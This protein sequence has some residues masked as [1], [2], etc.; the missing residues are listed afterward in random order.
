VKD[1][2]SMYDN[3]KMC[4][5]AEDYIESEVI[6]R[7]NYKEIHNL[8]RS[9]LDMCQDKMLKRILIGILIFVYDK[10]INCQKNINIEASND[11]IEN[12]SKNKFM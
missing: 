2:P 12:A 1:M 8:I 10:Q 5:T 7:E 9:A 11:Q 3:K 6:H 4:Y